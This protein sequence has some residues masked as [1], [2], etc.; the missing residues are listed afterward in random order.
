M[1]SRKLVNSTK[2]QILRTYTSNHTYIQEPGSGAGKD[3]TLIPGSYI[4]PEITSNFSS[5]LDK[6][7]NMLF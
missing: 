4:G 6:I 5:I 7:S 2:N 3:V 1:L